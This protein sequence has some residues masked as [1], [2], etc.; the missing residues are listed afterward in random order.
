MIQ[1][2]Y[3]HSLTLKSGEKSFHRH[4]MLDLV[5]SEL[6]SSAHIPLKVP[7]VEFDFHVCVFICQKP[8][9]EFK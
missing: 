3:I 4:A 1:S 8:N 6:L 5:I 9:V 2:L 7:K